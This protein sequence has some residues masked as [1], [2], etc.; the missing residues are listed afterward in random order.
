MSE[1]SFR[2]IYEGKILGQKNIW[3]NR[4]DPKQDPD[5]DPNPDPKLSEKSDPDPKKIISDPQHC[6]HPG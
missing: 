1:H 4:P 6:L 2:T 5:P 3:K